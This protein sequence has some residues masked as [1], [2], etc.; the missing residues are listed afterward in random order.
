MRSTIF[1]ILITALLLTFGL[2]SQ[3]R[4]NGYQNASEYMKAGKS[5]HHRSKSGTKTAGMKKNKRNIASEKKHKQ[6]RNVAS[7]KNKKSKKNKRNVAS[8]KK[9]KKSKSKKS[10]KRH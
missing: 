8:E 5:S 10:K 2:S 6:K 1:S 4:T 9:H 3:A 7:V